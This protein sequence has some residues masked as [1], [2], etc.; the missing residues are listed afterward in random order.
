MLDYM[1]QSSRQDV[2]LNG[3]SKTDGF[4]VMTSLNRLKYINLVKADMAFD[5]FRK[6]ALTFLLHIMY[7]I[8][9]RCFNYLLTRGG[10]AR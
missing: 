4:T 10:A 5:L 2:W 1:S 9:C 8:R 7:I 3:W 6:K